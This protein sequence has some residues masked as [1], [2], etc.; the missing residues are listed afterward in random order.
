MPLTPGGKAKHYYYAPHVDDEIKKILKD[1]CRNRVLR[2]QDGSGIT[3]SAVSVLS[4]SSTAAA[5]A[6]AVSGSIPPDSGSSSISPDSVSPPADA[7]AEILTSGNSELARVDDSSVLYIV[8]H[9]NLGLGI[10]THS[11]YSTAKDLT[12]LLKRDGL[13]ESVACLIKLWACNTGVKM[14]GQKSSYAAAFAEAMR[15]SFPNVSIYGYVGWAKKIY[16]NFQKQI[17]TTATTVS[18]GYEKRLNER[19]KGNKI[20][21]AEGVKDTRVMKTTRWG[22]SFDITFNRINEWKITYISDPNA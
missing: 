21:F 16:P 12:D 22:R 19:A 5:A 18:G 6:A 15:P 11:H 1:L 2:Q 9:G 20:L 8:G 10:G 14:P 17:D 13:K 7:F 4:S 3:S